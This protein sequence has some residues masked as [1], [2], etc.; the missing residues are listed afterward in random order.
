M[1]QR[2]WAVLR[3]YRR[4]LTVCLAIYWG[5]IFTATHTPIPP[6]A[7]P[8]VSDK[9][10]H[11]FAYAVLGVLLTVWQILRDERHRLTLRQ[12]AWLLGIVC[13]YGIADE[14]L[15]IPVNRH[16]DIY[17]FLADLAG[18]SV[19]ILAIWWLQPPPEAAKSGCDP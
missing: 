9:V 17:D 6:Q 2:L 14:L 7:I 3:R 12:A 18:G 5:V 8:P 1:R 13:L 10:L 19:G 11:Y 16:A 15:Q 4:L